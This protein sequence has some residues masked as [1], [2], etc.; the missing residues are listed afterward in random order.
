[1]FLFSYEGKEPT[2]RKLVYLLIDMHPL[3]NEDAIEDQLHE[4]SERGDKK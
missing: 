4:L 1:M 2:G 3:S